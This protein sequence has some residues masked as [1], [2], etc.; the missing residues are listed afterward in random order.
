LERVILLEK[1][2][3]PGVDMVTSHKLNCLETPASG[4]TWPENGSKRHK[5]EEEVEEEEVKLQWGMNTAAF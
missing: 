5:K 4:R 2:E 3:E 1:L